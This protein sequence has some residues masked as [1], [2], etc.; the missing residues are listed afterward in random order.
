MTAYLL[1]K[2][3]GRSCAVTLFE[4]SNRLGGKIVTRRFDT[5]PVLYEAG[6]AELYGYSHVGP[7]PLR[8][9]VAELGLATSPMQGQTVVLGDHLLKT[10]DDLDREFG[11]ATARALRRFNRQ[12]RALISPADYYESDWKEDNQDP[13]SHHSFRSLLA[14]VED[15]VARRYI[16]VAVHS[17][18]ATEPHLT[19]A[20]YGLQNYLMN[21]PE[22]MYL[23]SIDGGIERLPQELA[24]RLSARVLLNRRVVRVERTPQ[25]R[26]RVVARHQ[27]ETRAEEFDFVV[28]ALPNNWIPAV[29]WGG[30]TLAEAMHRHHK[31]YDY[32]A[33]YL[34]VSV[35]FDRPF[36]RDRIAESYFMLDAFGGCCVYDESSRNSDHEFGV[37]GWL[38]GGEAAL[39]M[40]NLDDGTLIDQ[41]LDSL[42]RCLRPGRQGLLEGRVHRWVGSVNGL[43]GGRPARDPDARHQPEPE[44]HPG[45]FVVGDYLFD[46]TING[47]LDSADVVAEWILEEIAEEPSAAANGSAHASPAPAAGAAGVVKNG[48]AP[49]HPLPLRPPHFPLQQ[50]KAS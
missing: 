24:R 6:A 14:R 13:L 3:T 8:E 49:A 23:Y 41:V 31:F 39:T 37:L 32:P 26:Y 1:E 10:V 34:R 35:L 17:D 44:E 18:L 2:R 11:E 27:G 46:S 28:V 16:E 29:E 47:L 45:L 40:S 36:W 22:Y 21:E 48:K 33:H 43:P 5:A 20:M 7:D 25:G 4:A 12:A 19:S 50:E 15:E 42:P 30:A 38:L 9:L